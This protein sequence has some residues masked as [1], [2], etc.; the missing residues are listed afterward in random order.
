MRALVA[1]QLIEEMAALGFPNRL[2]ARILCLTLTSRQVV[3][4]VQNFVLIHH[5]CLCV[6]LMGLRARQLIVW[7]FFFRM[8][9]LLRIF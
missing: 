6:R 9:S 4:R 7:N 1:L 2:V 5:S 8:G 3:S